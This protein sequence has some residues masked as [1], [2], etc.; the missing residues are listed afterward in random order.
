MK[1]GVDLLFNFYFA[2]LLCLQ[3]ISFSTQVVSAT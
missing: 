1:Q 3:G 2:E